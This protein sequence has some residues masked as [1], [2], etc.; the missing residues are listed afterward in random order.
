MWK[1]VLGGVGGA[2]HG[3]AAAWAQRDDCRAAWRAFFS[4]ASRSRRFRGSGDENPEVIAR[5]GR[6]RLAGTS[7]TG[8]SRATVVRST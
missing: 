3:P 7:T 1:P 2:G 4:R 8:V 5:L 6:G